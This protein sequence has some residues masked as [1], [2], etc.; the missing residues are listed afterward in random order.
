M[1]RVITGHRAGKSVIVDDSEV[2][3][4]WESFGRQIIPMWKTEAIPSIPLKQTDFDISVPPFGGLAFGESFANITIL[5][6]DD[7]LI[8]AAKEAGVN[9]GED[10]GMHTTETVDMV[11]IVSGE[12]WLKLDNGEEVR[13]KAGDCV[14][15][16]GTNHAWHNRTG[17]NCVLSVVMIGVQR[18]S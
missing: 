10:H 2:Q 15:Q 16:N 18:D 11:T 7:K 5:P 8:I 3:A 17:E 9:V 12:V 13:L 4:G 1:R 6:P 14:V